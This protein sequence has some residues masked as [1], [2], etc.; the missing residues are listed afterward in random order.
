MSDGEI[1]AELIVR[2]LLAGALFSG[3]QTAV[4]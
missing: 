2:V 3:D 1:S 4:L